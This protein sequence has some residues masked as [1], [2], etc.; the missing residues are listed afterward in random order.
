MLYHSRQDNNLRHPPRPVSGKRWRR[1][2]ET[3]EIRREKEK[4]EEEEE[5][6]E[7]EGAD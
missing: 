1:K 7:E 2:K 5:G 6:D 3:T 4:R